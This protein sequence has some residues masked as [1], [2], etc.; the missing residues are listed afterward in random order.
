M[1]GNEVAQLLETLGQL[2]SIVEEQLASIHD[3]VEHLAEV[4]REAVE[5]LGVIRSKLRRTAG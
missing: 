3:R 5:E 4:V 2:K 1:E